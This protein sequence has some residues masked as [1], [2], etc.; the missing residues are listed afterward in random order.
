VSKASLTKKDKA[1]SKKL[2]SMAPFKK[3]EVR[4]SRTKKSKVDKG[5][6]EGK[7]MKGKANERST[8]K[9]R[10]S[11]KEQSSELPMITQRSMTKGIKINEAPVDL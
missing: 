5:T 3:E 9:L 1:D 2:L 7:G 6:S 8:S 11:G 4:Q 10:N